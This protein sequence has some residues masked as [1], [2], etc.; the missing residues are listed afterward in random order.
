MAAGVV[1]PV[2]AADPSDLSCVEDR[3]ALL[4][5]LVGPTDVVDGHAATVAVRRMGKP[6]PTGCFPCRP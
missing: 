6:L 2:S 4:S 5:D 1:T 3:L